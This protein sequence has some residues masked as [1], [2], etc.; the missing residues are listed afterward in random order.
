MLRTATVRAPASY[1]SAS[2]AHQTSSRA[3]RPAAAE[4]L[5]VRRLRSTQRRSPPRSREGTLQGMLG[6]IAR[7]VTKD[8][9]IAGLYSTAQWGPGSPRSA[10]ASRRARRRAYLQLVGFFFRFRAGATRNTDIPISHGRTSS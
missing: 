2:A 7:N 9:R 1:L 10:V 8:T 5:V 3:A 4:A 6:W